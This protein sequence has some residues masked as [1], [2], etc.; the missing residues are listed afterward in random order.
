MGFKI[1]FWNRLRG[2]VFRD[3]QDNTATKPF[4]MI[5]KGNTFFLR[6]MFDNGER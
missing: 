5:N 6:E 1:V 4:K 2:Y 3:R